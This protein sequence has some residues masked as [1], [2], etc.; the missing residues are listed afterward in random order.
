M[1]PSSVDNNEVSP[2]PLPLA[3]ETTVPVDNE[4]SPTRRAIGINIKFMLPIDRGY[5]MNIETKDEVMEE[6]WEVK[7]KFATSS[8]GNAEQSL[9]DRYQTEA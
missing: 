9:Y 3:Y 5:R 4:M 1:S 7:N 8:G 2:R 6:L